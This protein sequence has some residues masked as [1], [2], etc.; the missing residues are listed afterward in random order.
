MSLV[1]QQKYPITKK[2]CY[3]SNPFLQLLV[4]QLPFLFNFLVKSDRDKVINE[5]INLATT[6]MLFF[7]SSWVNFVPFMADV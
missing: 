3:L 1:M 4:P 5:A 2:D 6:R 7:R